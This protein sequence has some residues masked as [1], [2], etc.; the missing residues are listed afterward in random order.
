MVICRIR[1][2]ESIIVISMEKK[3]ST[4]EKVASQPFE[5]TTLMD[6]NID[7][8]PA[9]LGQEENESGMILSTTRIGY[10]S[11]GPCETGYASMAPVGERSAS[12]LALE[13]E[14]NNQRKRLKLSPSSSIPIIITNDSSSPLPLNP[15]P[16][17]ATSL[18]KKAS[19][20]VGGWKKFYHSPTM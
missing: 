18:E 7:M 2:E 14:P 12:G 6:S 20:K 8:T 3:D 10:A 17:T 9:P 1:S 5:G 15:P 19:K 16:P 4:L 11:M 13:A